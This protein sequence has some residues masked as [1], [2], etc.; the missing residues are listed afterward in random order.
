MRRDMFAKQVLNLRNKKLARAK[1]ARKV[2]EK[3]PSGVIKLPMMELPRAAPVAKARV[4]HP[5]ITI[6]APPNS[7]KGCGCGRKRRI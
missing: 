1:P 4:S 7:S 5:A 2:V 3:T 6:K